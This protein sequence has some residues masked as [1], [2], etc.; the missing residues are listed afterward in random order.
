M[1]PAAIEMAAPMAEQAHERECS[2]EAVMDL[3]GRLLR[4]HYTDTGSRTPHAPAVALLHGSGPGTTG[5]SAF[6]LQRPAL[7]DAG[8]RLITPDLPGWGESERKPGK[9]YGFPQQAANV[10]AFIR[11][12]SPGTLMPSA[13]SATRGSGRKPR[14]STS[15]WLKSRTP[16]PATG[17]RSMAMPSSF[18]ESPS[19]TA[20][21]W[22]GPWI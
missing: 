2:R 5:W 12:L 13:Y 16:A 9:V 11:A 10:D 6:A 1:S 3:E 4:I 20:N 14:G 15:A 18:K 21:G 22:S 17:S 8:F 7:E 19:A